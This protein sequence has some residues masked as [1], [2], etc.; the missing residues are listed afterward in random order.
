MNEVVQ[1]GACLG[2][3]LAAVGTGKEELFEDLKQTL[4]SDNAVAGESAA[5]SIGLLLLGAGAST[6][7]AEGAIRELLGYAHD[8][9]H[10]KIIRGLALA[11]ALIMY[12]QE[13]NAEPLI[14]QLSRD[15][16]SILRYGAMFTIGLAYAGTANNSAVRRLL[17][18]AVS[19]VSDDVRRAAV[20]NLGFVLFRTTEQ[21]PRLVSLL[22]E[23]FNPHVR[24]GSCIAVGIACAGT[25]APEAAALLEPML[26]DVV[27]YVRQAAMIGLAMVYMQQAEARVP[28][29]KAF[30]ERLAAVIPDKHQS[31]MTKLGAILATGI[32][33]AG[34]RNVTLSMQSR[35]GFTKSSAVVGL[36]I[37]VQYWYW[38]PLMHF[39]SL[40][41][42]P[43]FLIGLNKDFK[44]P[45]KFT[46]KC[47]ARPSQFAYPK[48]LEE[49]KEEKKERVVTAV[50][51]TTAKA[52]AREAKKKAEEGGEHMEVDAP[53]D[54]EG[55]KG[56]EEKK[57]G[58]GGGEGGEAAG[59]KEGGKE[60][61]AAE[62]EVEGEAAAA[63]EK[64][65]PAEPEPT[66]FALSN[67]A[68]VTQ[69][70]EGVVSFLA[71]AEQRYVPVR[72]SHKPTGIV[73]L[74]DRTPGE[75]EEVV[76]VEAPPLEG[77][78]DEAEPPEPFEWTVPN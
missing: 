73:M 17:H 22:A 21:V 55:S 31:T 74:V 64:A 49:K 23:S 20:I 9:Q 60:G 48:K 61:E 28:K 51:S 68:R 24:Y 58:E 3:G 7:L 5:L 42:T 78:E 43:T 2:L 30:R 39:L 70:Q 67:P 57:E 25:G 65:K 26:D 69:A 14:E 66:S 33:D 40:A 37:W 62:V 45:T 13:E 36:A 8:T 18:V 75:P 50:L 72:R 10:E 56:V 34:G 46:A 12:G 41:F 4:Y 59:E 71:G 11:L 44:L 6:P 53:K 76:D 27:D 35:A 54:G 63:A 1:H 38:Y 32:L 16:D 77:D 52:K 29:A 47:G 19:D 15:R